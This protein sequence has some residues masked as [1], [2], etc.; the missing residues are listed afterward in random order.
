MDL[1]ARRGDGD[2]L[3]AHAAAGWRWFGGR[4]DLTKEVGRGR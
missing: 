2:T 3:D 4:D 1:L